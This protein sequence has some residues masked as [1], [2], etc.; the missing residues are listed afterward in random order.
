MV[1]TAL[2]LTFIWALL[3]STMVTGQFTRFASAQVNG[4]IIITAEGDVEPSTAPIQR[5]GDVYTLTNDIGVVNY[6]AWSSIGLKV[7]KDNIVIDGANFTL[8]AK[9]TNGS[10]GTPYTG[11]DIGLRDN[12]EVR[13]LEIS[14]FE[15]GIFVHGLYYGEEGDR[16]AYCDNITIANNN[17]T[18]CKVGIIAGTCCRNV[19]IY[20]NYLSKNDYGLEVASTRESLISG[21]YFAENRFGANI[22]ASSR[23]KIIENNFVENTE[24]AVR[25]SQA[26][27]NTFYHNNFINNSLFG[28]CQIS[29][30]WIAAYSVGEN[31]IWDNGSIGNYWNDFK[32]RFPT[33]SEIFGKGVWNTPYFINEENIDQYPLVAPYGTVIDTLP[34]LPCLLVVV[35]STVAITGLAIYLKKSKKRKSEGAPS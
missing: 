15:R 32:Q 28:S 30:P 33:A 21:N 20:E 35:I 8:Y 17:I 26:T 6:A 3:F 18:N 13:N 27:N 19:T 1:R 12:V 31:N 7:L 25:L 24:G 23:N 4:P 16:H 9:Y 29:N 10:D 34:I 5:V 11:I 14:G 22:V 2:T